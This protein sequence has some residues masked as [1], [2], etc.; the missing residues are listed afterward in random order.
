MQKNNLALI[1]LVLPFLAFAQNLALN[2]PTEQS[3]TYVGFVSSRAVDGSTGIYSHT[4]YNKTDQWWK[5]D[6]ESTYTINRIVVYNR[7]GT[8]EQEDR[9]IGSKVMVSLVNSSDPNDYTELYTL[10]SD[11][12]QDQTGL[13]VQGRYIMVYQPSIGP[14]HLAEVEVFGT[15]GSSDTQ[16]PT[17]PTLSNTGQSQTTADLSWS[18]A[19][20]NTA[21]TGYKIFK[22][23]ALEATFGNVSTYQVTGLT[24]STTYG[25]TATALDAAGNESVTSN[26]VSVTTDSSGGSSGGSTV[27]SES[28]GDIS[29]TTG[30][31]GIGTS[32][33]PSE[34]KLAVNGKI[35]SEELKVQLQSAWPDYVFNKDYKLPTLEE[36]QKHIQEKGHLINIPSADEVEA[37]GVELGEMNKLLLE[38]IE[39]LT[40]YILK[41]QQKITAMDRRLEIL[42]NITI[43]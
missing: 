34:Y 22:D 43:D 41:Q 39:E 30:N 4:H 24:A 1:L 16:N 11:L 31:V 25:F 32:S 23:G 35:I 14:L 19:T 2:K 3:T 42:E 28:S 7:N 12:V 38:K 18:G 5:V 8:T 36:I 10:T 9:L 13:N 37:N 21:V 17:A 15:A 40:L 29:Y 33:I 27:W 26:I 20:D 6:L